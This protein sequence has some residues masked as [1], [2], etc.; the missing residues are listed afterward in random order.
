MFIYFKY[1][2]DYMENGKVE[3]SL[4]LYLQAIK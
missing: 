4:D 1:S 3:D 2:N